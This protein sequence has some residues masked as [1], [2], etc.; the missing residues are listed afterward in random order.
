MKRLL[1]I[2]ALI[3]AMIGC[4]NG[5]SMAL[6]SGVVANIGKHKVTLEEF[7]KR[8]NVFAAE[9]G[10]NPNRISKDIV[11]AN[12]NELINTKLLLDQAKKSGISVTTEEIN[13]ELSNL[14][15]GYTETQFDK[16]F[17]EKLIDKRLWLKQLQEHLI[18]K[19]LLASHFSAITV[20]GAAIKDYY[21]T[22]R[23]DFSEPEMI[24]AMQMQFKSMDDAQNALNLLNSGQ[25]FTSIA[26]KYSISPD[27]SSGGDMGWLSV[28]ELPGEF[29]DV[30]AT[31][32]AGKNSGIVKTRF[33][34][35]IFLVAAKLPGH[36]KSL[37]ESEDEIAGILKNQMMDKEL[38][39]WLQQLRTEE[40]VNINYELLKRAGLI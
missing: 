11:L 2:I 19:K 17:I 30:L 4:R 31:L 22:H 24:H 10:V 6:S 28:K 14:K 8:L 7:K 9:T 25:S 16:I 38:S 27:A 13:K 23:K 15:Q 20:N 35:Q 18:I 3:P 26:N 1:I 32:P 21:D 12:L 37:D 5:T 40:D 36:T 33:G 39:Q 29:V 34:Y